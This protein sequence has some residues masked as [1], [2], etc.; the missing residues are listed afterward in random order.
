[1]GGFLGVVPACVTTHGSSE[2]K[3]LA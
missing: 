2:A 1:M 3:A